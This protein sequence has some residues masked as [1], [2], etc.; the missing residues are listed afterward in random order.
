[1]S[2]SSSWY[3]GDVGL[4]ERDEREEDAQDDDG[5]CPHGV[6][7]EFCGNCHEDEADDPVGAAIVASC[8]E[9]R[10]GGLVVEDIP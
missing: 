10:F 4:S 5:L 9:E 8:F 1:M 3:R 7:H 2:F 6:P